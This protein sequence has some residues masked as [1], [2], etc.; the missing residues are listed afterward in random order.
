MAIFISNVLTE[1]S[2]YIFKQ[3]IIILFPCF[4]LYITI[5]SDCSWNG[6]MI[7]DNQSVI[8]LQIV[9]FV[10]CIISI[11]SP[12]ACHYCYFYAKPKK[13]LFIHCK[14]KMM[15]Y[16]YF[17]VA[18][19][20]L[21]WASDIVSAMLNIHLQTTLLGYQFSSCVRSCRYRSRLSG[22]AHIKHQNG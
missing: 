4:A 7:L 14:Y 1:Y 17:I 9:G 11:Y 22:T 3:A 16:V 10:L 20:F 12:C 15:N 21:S 13:Y 19:K 8:S 18:G 2:S 6:L 5:Q